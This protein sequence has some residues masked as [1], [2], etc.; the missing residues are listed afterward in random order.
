[1]RKPEV[2]DNPIFMP[3]KI[4]GVSDAKQV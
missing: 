2:I 1:V 3:S 4:N